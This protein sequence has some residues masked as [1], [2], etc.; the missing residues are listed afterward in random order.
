[1]GGTKSTGANGLSSLNEDDNL[2]AKPQHLQML[3]I[4]VRHG[5]RADSN[6]EQDDEKSTIEKI[7]IDPLLA[8]VGK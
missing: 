5:E 2:T 8:K 3:L 7:D 4:F 1:M 6:P